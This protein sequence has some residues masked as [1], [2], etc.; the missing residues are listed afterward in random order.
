MDFNTRSFGIFLTLFLTLN[1]LNINTFSGMQQCI[2]DQLWRI[3]TIQLINE[4]NNSHVHNTWYHA[5]TILFHIIN[6]I[7]I[8]VNNFIL[9]VYNFCLKSN[10]KKEKKNKSV[11]QF[12][13]SVLLSR[14]SSCL[15][16]CIKNIIVC[17]K[18]LRIVVARNG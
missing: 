11:W 17:M 13:N 18:I 5:L 16:I 7:D 14:L 15:I 3:L 1:F 9:I 6:T 4:T 2:H 10:L 12:Y 8:C